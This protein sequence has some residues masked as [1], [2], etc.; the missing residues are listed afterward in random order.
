MHEVAADWYEPMVLQRFM[1]PSI[2]SISG[3]LQSGAM[4]LSNILPSQLVTLSL[5]HVVVLG[6]PLFISLP[7]EGR[8]LSWLAHT[9]DEKLAQGCLH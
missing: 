2:A 6:K 8:K 5:H 1:Q 7:A 9:V 3:Q 4:Q